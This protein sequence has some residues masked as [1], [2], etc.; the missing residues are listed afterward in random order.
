MCKFCVDRVLSLGRTLEVARLAV[1]ENPLNQPPADLDL[2]NPDIKRRLELTTPSFINS[3]N[4]STALRIALI[5]DKKWKP[6]REI[7]ITFLDGDPVVQQKVTDIALIWTQYASIK[8]NFG[9]HVNADIRISFR[10]TGSWSYIGID[11][12]GIPLSSATMNYGW[13]DKSTSD[14]EYYRV[15]LHEFG[16]ALACIH[17]HQHPTNGINW[18]KSAVY[19]SLGGSPNFW[20][21]EEIDHNMFDRYSQTISQYSQF[22][23]RSIMLYSFPREWTTDGFSAPYNSRLSDTDIKFIEEVYPFD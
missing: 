21:K 3:S 19:A 2:D 11:A 14:E 20:S 8:F 5:T 15:V 22:D 1:E 16:H 4:I 18:N 13:L 17:E 6:G 7:K 12:L 10:D 9:Y 23:T